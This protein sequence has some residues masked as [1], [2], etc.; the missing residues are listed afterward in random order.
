MSLEEN[1]Y[2]TFSAGRAPDEKI[3]F[4][5]SK[6]FSLLE[7]PFGIWC[8]FHAP[9]EA[10][11]FESN[12]Y[13]NLKVRTDKSNRDS[14]ITQNFPNTFFIK[15]DNITERFKATLAAMARG[16]EAIAS[17]SLWNLPE[18]V[19]CGVNLLVKIPGEESVFGPYH[20]KIIQL[21]RAHD[22]KDHYS[23]Q[24]SLSNKI[25]WQIQGVFPTYARVILN[26]KD[27]KINCVLMSERLEQE[28]AK[29]RGIKDGTFEP[30]PHKPPKAASSPWRVYANKVVTERKDLLMLPHLSAAMRNLLKEAGY[31]TTDDVANADLNVLKTILEDPWATESY[32]TSIAY[33]HN[34]PVLK[35][36]GVFPPPRKKH[37]LYFDFEAT[38]TFTK[39]N[40]SFVY[41]IGVWDAEENKFISFVAKNKEEEEKIFSDFFDYIKEPQDTILYHWT[42]YEVKK[43]RSLASKYPDIAQKLNALANMCLDLK[44]LIGKA[45]Y[46]P[47]PSLSLK[48]AAPAFGF[49]W[50]QG[51]CGAMDSMVFYTN[52]CKTG[53]NNLIEKVL[54]YNEDDCKAMIYLDE[55]LQKIEIIKPV[56]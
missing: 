5:A 20:Y 36:E 52:W 49:N 34:K 54:M 30:E 38:E 18:N 23:L 28:L 4:H 8:D 51:D 24:V 56:K 14:W 31:K 15:A 19:F 32:Y 43:M 29:W 13:E 47:S 44:I 41:L 10:S 35:E 39:D 21:K 27:A 45:F 11:V 22:I 25:L 55:Y 2:N 50:R 12:R 7:D 9:R 37:N 1:L 46:L 40:E 16:E 3:D 42:E 26:G 48:A 17:A 33:M 53:D 6:M